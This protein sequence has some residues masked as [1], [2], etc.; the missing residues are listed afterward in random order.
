[1]KEITITELEKNSSQKKEAEKA[2]RYDYKPISLYDTSK[3]SHEEWLQMRQDN[4][5]IGGSEASAVLD[6]SPWTCSRELFDKKKGIVPKVTKEFNEE[7]KKIGT[8]LEPVVQ[9]FFIMWFEKN[10]GHRLTVCDNAEQFNNESYAI[11]NDKHF[12]QCGRRDENGELLFPFVTGNVDGLI[13]VNG[14]IG[15]L[16]YKTTTTHG[17]QK[18]VVAKWRKGMPPEYY[19]AQVRQYM[20]CLNLEYAFLVCV[21]GL[22]LQDMNAVYIERDYDIE[23]NLFMAEKTFYEANINGES[24]DNSECKAS[25]LSNYY[26]RLY[27]EPDPDS[28]PVELS[29]AYYPVLEK[30]L[31]RSIRREGM[32]KALKSMDEEDDQLVALLSPILQT[33]SKC[34]C[35]NKD[36]ETIF[37]KVSM[38]HE[39]HSYPQIRNN[40]KLKTMLDLDALKRDNPLIYEKYQ[41]TVFDARTFKMEHPRL[42][43]K[44]EY[45]PKPTGSTYSYKAEKL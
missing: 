19:E 5:R 2:R 18:N 41:E 25:L 13:K 37:L 26:T 15:I 44:Y 45:A 14:R 31:S 42:F 33:S 9:Q 22:S 36:G 21:W 4:C 27:G 24:W 7:N 40:E 35:K 17:S 10:Y 43:A 29:G 16:E 28:K 12:Y 20:G 11:Y 6:K 32:N 30:M 1:M 39:R 38:P 3:M 8:L 34:F 23:E